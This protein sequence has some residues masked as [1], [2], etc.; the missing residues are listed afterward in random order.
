MGEMFFGVLDQKEGHDCLLPD[1]GKAALMTGW[2]HPACRAR[3]VT[4][5]KCVEH[6]DEM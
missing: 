4:C 3:E 5:R 2:A 1:P 6:N